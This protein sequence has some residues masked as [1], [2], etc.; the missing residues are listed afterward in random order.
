MEGYKDQ[1]DTSGNGGAL[2]FRGQNREVQLNCIYCQ[3]TACSAMNGGAVSLAFLTCTFRQADFT[4]CRAT[5][6]GGGL[7]MTYCISTIDGTT[8]FQCD[9]G[10]MGGGLYAENTYSVK[11]AGSTKFTT[12]T[13]SEDGSSVNVKYTVSPS[14]VEFSGTATAKITIQAG[15]S[16]NNKNWK[17]VLFLQGKLLGLSNV[18]FDLSRLGN[19][20]APLSLNGQ[21]MQADPS[22][23]I[24]SCKFS[25]SSTS[26]NFNNGLVQVPQQTFALS[27][28]FEDCQ[29]TT[30][31]SQKGG[32]VQGSTL[33]SLTLTNCDFSGI[34]SS[35][36][37]GAVHTGSATNVI[38]KGCT[39]GST[40]ATFGG[41]IFV[42]TTTTSIEIQATTF[43]GNSYR[44]GAVCFAN[45]AK[46]ET[47]TIKN[48]TFQNYA[49]NSNPASENCIFK[50]SEVALTL[51]EI[52]FID[53]E[54][55]SATGIASG[56]TS[57]TL[58][59]CDF[60]N[61]KLT[62]PEQDDVSKNL[63]HLASGGA[64]TLANCTFTDCA[65][66]GKGGIV[67]SSEVSGAKTMAE[68]SP[69]QSIKVD[70]CEFT[71][72]S[73]EDTPELSFTCQQLTITG[74]TFHC[75]GTSQSSFIAISITGE[76]ESSVSATFTMAGA[77]ASFVHP[78]IDFHS[79]T[80]S[81]TTFQN[82]EFT[83]NLDNDEEPDIKYVSLQND[84]SVSFKEDV[85]F[86]VPRD[87]AVSQTGSG[88]VHFPG[89]KPVD[90]GDSET[91]EEPIEGD[92]SPSDN[93]NPGEKTPDPGDTSPS[94]GGD[95]SN[96]GLIVGVTVGVIVVVAAVI[97]GVV[98]LLRR[99]KRNTFT[100][101]DSACEL[102]ESA[103]TQAQEEMVVT[104]AGPEFT[105]NE[106]RDL[107]PF[108]DFEEAVEGQ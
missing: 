89:E 38:L 55:N 103:A 82:S 94:E 21:E 56:V 76:S 35:S 100:S 3:F 81:E 64:H 27:L 33:E 93:L 97:V 90:P 16:Q 77:K 104:E 6:N 70:G 2:S 13:S 45:E 25:G 86:D 62:K 108:D 79:S 41:A 43:D 46:P 50:M 9:A 17:S 60:T 85:T 28:S 42:S 59:G 54:M 1:A 87:S 23:S 7:Y 98:F 74:S 19:V 106:P 67:G 44:N 78:L 4:N 96:T 61:V 18:E 107:E 66:S 99:R 65:V 57:L 84:G 8:F 51:Q 105:A 12:C 34:V 73:S 31:K 63:I 102:D 53:I 58:T 11:I 26:N 32:A 15:A 36:E 37:G 71:G 22:I 20:P 72:C 83:A 91:V 95:P 88:D 69:A 24:K 40:T 14:T 5:N 39:I 49:T 80:G 101:E 68:T 10:N 29:F 75:T 47:M 92:T 52:I 30:L 48:C